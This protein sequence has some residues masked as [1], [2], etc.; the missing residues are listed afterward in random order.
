VAGTALGEVDS[1]HA[2]LLVKRA[3]EIGVAQMADPGS[4][5]EAAAVAVAEVVV[6]VEGE[7]P[8]VAETREQKGKRMRRHGGT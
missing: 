4:D 1:R 8:G 6:V 2:I 3:D 5:E 7:I